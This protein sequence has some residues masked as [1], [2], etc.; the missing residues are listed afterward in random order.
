MNNISNSNFLTATET[1]VNFTRKV[2]EKKIALNVR[3]T[4]SNDFWDTICIDQTETTRVAS[5]RTAISATR[6]VFLKNG[7][8]VFIVNLLIGYDD[9]RKLNKLRECD[10]DVNFL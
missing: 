2:N 4:E 1:F 9:D 6:M 5:A 8:I 10:G 3:S 7:T